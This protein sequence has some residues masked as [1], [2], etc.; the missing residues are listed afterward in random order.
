VSEEGVFGVKTCPTAR[1]KRS[2]DLS[3]FVSE[4]AEKCR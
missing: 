2:G 3:V 1:E 4:F